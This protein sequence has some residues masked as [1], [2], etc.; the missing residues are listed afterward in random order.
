M[1]AEYI[2][3]R[4]VGTNW[5]EGGHFMSHFVLTRVID[6]PL[7]KVWAAADFTKS[8]GPY[9]MKVQNAGDPNKNGVGFTRAVTSGKRTIIEKLLEVDPMRSYTYTLAEGAPVREDYRGKVAFSSKGSA[10][11][12][13]WSAD[14]TA[15]APGTG[16]ICVLAIKYTVNRILNSI[17]AECRTTAMSS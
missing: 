16:W 6:A 9:P 15:K 17:E 11:L 10:T 12:L 8:A 1:Q 7:E 4:D 5:M 13:T 3:Y 14:F 2:Y